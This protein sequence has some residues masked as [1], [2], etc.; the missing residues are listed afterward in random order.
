MKGSIYLLIAFLLFGC[1]ENQENEDQERLTIFVSIPPQAG[2]VK[3]LALGHDTL[4]VVSLVSEGQ[5]PHAYEPTA[6]Q[7]AK[8]AQ[9]DVLFTIGLPFEHA[10]L[11]KI[12]PLYPNLRII[13]TQQGIVRRTMP[14]T[15][16]GEPC[17]HDHGQ[18]DPHI[19]LS[20][21]NASILANNMQ[22]TL[23]KLDPD[24]SELYAKNFAQLARQLA[25]DQAYFVDQFKSYQGSRFYVFHP[26]FGYFADAYGLKQIPVELE[27][28]SP[29]PRQLVALINQAK[30]DGVKVVFVQKQFPA[31]SAKAI[32]DAIGGTVVQ[33]DPLA[34]DGV[35]NLHRIGES[36]AQALKK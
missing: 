31:S 4:E 2:L 23:S 9:A 33:L 5:S 3:D 15:H 11:K 20:H 12:K 13:E 6:K 25:E 22:R 26:S 30:A 8:F 32:A 1:A 27:G 29:S 24:H 7:L 28:K 19:W 21:D 36:I 34:E 10:L 18:Q 17:T 35:A 16:H 14:H